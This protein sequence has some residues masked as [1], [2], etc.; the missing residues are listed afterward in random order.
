METKI[1]IDYWSKIVYYYICQEGTERNG[2]KL[3]IDR[4]EG[5]PIVKKL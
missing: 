3:T 2:G 1:L 4:T 5:Q